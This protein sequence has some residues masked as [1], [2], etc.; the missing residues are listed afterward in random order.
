MP[1]DRGK[2]YIAYFAWLFCKIANSW[3][4]EADQSL[5]AFLKKYSSANGNARH[6]FC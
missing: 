6:D 1:I 5:L 3:E 4:R 2:A